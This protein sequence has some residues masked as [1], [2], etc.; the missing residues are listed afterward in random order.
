MSNVNTVV[1]MQCLQ[2]NSCKDG[3]KKTLLWTEHQTYKPFSERRLFRAGKRRKMKFSRWQCSNRCFSILDETDS[4]LDIDALRI[5]AT[6]VNKL[7]RPDNATVYNYALP[8]P[9]WYIVPDVVHVCSKDGFVK[10]GGKELALEL[11]EKGYEWIK[12][13]L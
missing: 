11:E 2:L 3:G 7:R 1:W 9:A 10:T 5:V 8:A 13:E 12:K 4:G 6:G